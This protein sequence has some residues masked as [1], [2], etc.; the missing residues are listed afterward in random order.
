MGLGRHGA[1]PAA[2][3]PPGIGL[4]L[5]ACGSGWALVVINNLMV[6]LLLVE[7]HQDLG[8]PLAQAGQVVA[9]YGFTAGLAAPVI[10]RAL[11]RLGRRPLMLAG[12]AVLLV[13]NV[14]AALAPS[15]TWLLAARA[16]AAL[17]TACLQPASFALVGDALPYARRGWAM[18][19]VMNGSTFANL[20]GVPV[21]TLVAGTLGWRWAFA[22]AAALSLAAAAPVLAGLRGV[23]AAGGPAV[24]APGR[25]AGG[26]RAALRPAV[27]TTLAFFLGSLAW[28]AWLT[29]MAAFYRLRFGVTTA[30]VAP[31]VSAIGIGLL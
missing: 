5:L 12:L 6:G 15:F 26:P 23:A 31:L 2:T 30:E 10:G 19:W 16:V 21:T 4:L 29:Y 27:A 8:V 1:P 20:V 24:G 17:G 28:F 14:T 11:D 18:G 22:L 7:L 9:V 13:A 25:L 3:V